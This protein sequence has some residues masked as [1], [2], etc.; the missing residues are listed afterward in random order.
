[1]STAADGGQDR[2]DLLFPDR[3]GLALAHGPGAG[4]GAGRHPDG[5][6]PAGVGQIGGGVPGGDAGE[7]A[8]DRGGFS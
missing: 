3:F 5:Q 2:V 8:L 4:M 7:V 6:R 1:L